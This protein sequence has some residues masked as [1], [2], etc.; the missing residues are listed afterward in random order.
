M[1]VERYRSLPWIIADAEYQLMKKQALKT[2][3]P[4]ILYF[5]TGHQFS[6]HL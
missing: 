6:L 1:N 3:P 2:G 4:S 5:V